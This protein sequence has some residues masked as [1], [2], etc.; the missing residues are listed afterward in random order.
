MGQLAH[1]EKHDERVCQYDGECY[2]GQAFSHCGC[3]QFTAC[4]AEDLLR[5]DCS[6]ALGDLRKEEVDVIYEG[7]AYYKNGYY[8]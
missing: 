4:A 1:V 2:Q 3:N 8:Q 5:V 7:Y 6:D